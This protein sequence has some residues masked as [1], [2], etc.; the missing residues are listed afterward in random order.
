[1]LA[2]GA[3]R[4]KGA[5]VA[6]GAGGGAVGGAVAGGR[7]AHVGDGDADRAGGAEGR[8]GLGVAVAG[9]V[10]EVGGGE[11]VGRLADAHASLERPVGPPLAARRPGGGFGVLLPRAGFGLHGVSPRQCEAAVPAEW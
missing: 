6:G 3:S 1:M 10:A 7:G 5:I 4:P 8:D 2:S 9:G 11:A